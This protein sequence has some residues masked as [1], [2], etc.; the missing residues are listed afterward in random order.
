MSKE[1]IS[2]LSKD[3][4]HAVPQK[5]AALSEIREAEEIVGCRFPA[6]LREMLMEMNGVH[7]FASLFPDFP[8]SGEWRR[9]SA[10]AFAVAAREQLLPDGLHYELSPDYHLVFYVCAEQLYR[11]AREDGT[12]GDCI[13]RVELRGGSYLTFL[14]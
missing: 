1:L 2:E 13:S 7:S 9:E 4:K 8:E 12:L 5:P 11:R 10:R 14:G 6:E 3:I